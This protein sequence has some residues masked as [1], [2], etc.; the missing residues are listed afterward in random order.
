MSGSLL[1]LSRLFKVLPTPAS[2]LPFGGPQP[3]WPWDSAVLTRSNAAECSSTSLRCWELGLPLIALQPTHLSALIVPDEWPLADLRVLQNFFTVVRVYYCFAIL[4]RWIECISVLQYFFCQLRNH[5]IATLQ[6]V[7]KRLVKRG[8]RGAVTKVAS[9]ALDT[10]RAFPIASILTC[11]QFENPL[12]NLRQFYRN[13]ILKY[14]WV[15]WNY[16]WKQIR[17]WVVDV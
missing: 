12:T 6:R 14:S 16:G 8:V 4:L 2:T 13:R 3:S 5:S 9:S 1:I 10:M 11:E 7:V 17:E 15:F